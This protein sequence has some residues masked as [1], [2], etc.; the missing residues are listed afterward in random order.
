MTR[1]HVP[2]QMACNLS[3]S[4]AQPCCG[5]SLSLLAISKGPPVT[6]HMRRSLIRK[7]ENNTDA[8]QLPTQSNQQM[9]IAVSMVCTLA[10]TGL[11]R[12]LHNIGRQVVFT[13]GKDSAGRDVCLMC[14]PCG[15][16]NRISQQ[17]SD[18]RKGAR[19]LSTTPGTDDPWIVAPVPVE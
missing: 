14:H 5:L 15:T 12:L 18:V 11:R 1:H 4:A 3:D 9:L 7:A 6:E 13:A 8:Y 16:P 2:Y 19:P 17:T 10:E